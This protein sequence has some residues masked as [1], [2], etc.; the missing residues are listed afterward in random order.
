MEHTAAISSTL[1]PLLLAVIGCLVVVLLWLGKRMHEKLDKLMVHRES[2]F[3]CFAA[4]GS[5][6]ADH[7][8]FFK[9]TNDHETRLTMLENQFGLRGCEKN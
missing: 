1:I 7:A 4:K 2:C 5:N 3:L 9:R 6:D 8:E